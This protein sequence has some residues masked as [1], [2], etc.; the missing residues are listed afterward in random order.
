MEELTAQD[1]LTLIKKRA[2]W[3]RENGESDMRNIL[4][5][6]RGIEGDIAAG[7]TRDEIMADDEDDSE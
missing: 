3:C 1:V 4:N 6:I 5:T 7:K 2:Q